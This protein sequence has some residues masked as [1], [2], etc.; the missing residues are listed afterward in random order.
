[1]LGEIRY[2]A[3]NVCPDGKSVGGRRRGMLNTESRGRYC[4]DMEIA[5]QKPTTVARCASGPYVTNCHKSATIFVE[6][7]RVDRIA[8]AFLLAAGPLY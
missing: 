8:P 5:G 3:R 6:D 7:L 4:C 2:M 1:M